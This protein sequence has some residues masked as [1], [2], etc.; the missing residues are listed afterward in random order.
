MDLLFAVPLM[1]YGICLENVTELKITISYSEFLEEFEPSMLELPKGLDFTRLFPK[2]C[3]VSVDDD[4][5]LG[6]PLDVVSAFVEQAKAVLSRAL[7]DR[8]INIKTLKIDHMCSV[9][10]CTL[11]VLSQIFPDV[12][13]LHT[14][15]S[16]RVPFA[17]LREYFLCLEEVD[18]R[19][20]EGPFY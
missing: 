10:R 18:E 14:K 9:E 7:P 20:F 15:R 6:F 3:E 1:C 8:A 11:R 17:L 12:K 4:F 16:Q 2:L 13:K 5:S 19:S